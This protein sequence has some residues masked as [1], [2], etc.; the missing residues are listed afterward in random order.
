MFDFYFVDKMLPRN[1][2]LFS[3]SKN[4]VLFI[5]FFSEQMK[6]LNLA[7]FLL[8]SLLFGLTISQIWKATIL[9]IEVLPSVPAS[10]LF[11]YWNLTSLNWIRSKYI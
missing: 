9:L 8:L 11:L 5:Y 10:F 4:K 6:Y 1:M 2:V 3:L 7:I